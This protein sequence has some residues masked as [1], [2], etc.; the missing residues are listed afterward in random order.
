[1]KKYMVLVTS[2][3]EVE[4]DEAKFDE[5]MLASFRELFY[6]FHS[7]REHVEHLAQLCA[8]GI[9]QNGFIEGY[10]KTAEAGIRFRL[11]DV[12]DI[13]IEEEEK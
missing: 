7:I 11:V 4:I 3:V 1:M 2:E 13:H 6:P 10:G 8:R 9:D 5:P 12:T